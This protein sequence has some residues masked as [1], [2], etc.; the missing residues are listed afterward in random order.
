[1]QSSFSGSSVG[2]GL[3]LTH[4]LVN[5][6]KGTIEYKE[7]EGGG[8]IFTVT[9]PTDTS[10]YEEK[11]FLIPHNV[12]LE[13]ENKRVE[14]VEDDNK[15][16]DLD[17]PLNKRKVLIIE[18]DNDVRDFL[19]AEIGHYFE[20]EVASDG[21]SGLEKAKEYDADL[22]IC[23]VLMPGM[24][25]FEVTRQLKNDFNTSHIPI[26]LLTAMSSAESHLEGVENGADAYITK[27]FS[28][29]LLLSR[30]IKLIEQREKLREKFSNEPNMTR[31]NICTSEKDKDFADKLAEILE[32][33]ISNAQF[34]VDEFAAMMNFGRTVFY[35]K[36]RGVTGYSPNEYIRIMRMKKAAELLKEGKYTV[37]EIS[38]QVGIND[39]FYFSK[40]F[41][42][43]FGVSP[44][45]FTKQ[46]EGEE[47]EN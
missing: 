28:P 40:C 34:S 3:H 17:E 24:T 20:V 41:K 7:N 39:P 2:V 38:Y 27:P 31:P 15:G 18:D 45:A 44:S 11:D 16:A 46:T 22:I 26:I 4:E 25:G 14:V 23:D 42:Q 5:V 13:E 12:L 21:T 8:S 47:D 1:M 30:V 35:R 32:R 33:E 9:L 29:K 19:K 43:Q 6:H 37:A 36:V 10:V